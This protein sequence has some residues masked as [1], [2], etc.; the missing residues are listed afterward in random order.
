MRGL[1]GSLLLLLGMVNQIDG[2]RALTTLAA[3]MPMCKHIMSG[4][5]TTREIQMCRNGEQHRGGPFNFPHMV[6]K[7]T[8]MHIVMA[9]GILL[10]PTDFGVE[11]LLLNTYGLEPP[12]Q[13]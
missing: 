12:I 6:M 2:Q 5:M 9:Q 3:M 4:G 8:C 10:L 7:C 1:F 13:N 11:P